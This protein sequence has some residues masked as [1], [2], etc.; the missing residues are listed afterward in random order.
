MYNN[1]NICII[2][3]R[4]P[5]QQKKIVF[6]NDVMMTSVGTCS[7]SS[8]AEHVLVLEKK[9]KKIP[10]KILCIFRQ[11][12]LDFHPQISILQSKPK[13]AQKKCI[14]G[15]TKISPNFLNPIKWTPKT[16]KNDGFFSKKIFSTSLQLQSGL[17]TKNKLQTKRN[18][19]KMASITKKRETKKINPKIVAQMSSMLALIPIEENLNS[20]GSHVNI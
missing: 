2:N 13:N 15:R 10:P 4:I 1:F 9:K 18:L 20:I 11:K 17:K 19:K 16:I 8:P 6:F 3:Q 14:L 7:S 12:H 5:R